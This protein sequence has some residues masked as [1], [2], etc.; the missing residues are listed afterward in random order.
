MIGNLLVLLGLVFQT[1]KL[2]SSIYILIIHIYQSEIY[3]MDSIIH[4]LNNWGLSNLHIIMLT[5]SKETEELKI[6]H[7]R[8]Y[9]IYLIP[10]LLFSLKGG[11]HDN[12]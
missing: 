2:L 4:T 1:D 3:L 5:D 11:P 8:F 9:N 7:R 10:V 6:H 12:S